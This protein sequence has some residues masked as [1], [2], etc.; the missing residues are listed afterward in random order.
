MFIDMMIMGFNGGVDGDGILFLCNCSFANCMLKQN[1]FHG[2]A[3]IGYVSVIYCKRY[4][5][6]IFVWR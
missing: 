5:V 3:L 4:Y 1:A 2:F 6:L